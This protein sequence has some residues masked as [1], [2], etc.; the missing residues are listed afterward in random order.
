M[1]GNMTD[2][3]AATLHSL[4]SHGSNNG[5]VL[6]T[7]LPQPT[8]GESRP[9]SLRSETEVKRPPPVHTVMGPPLLVRGTSAD[10]GN[11]ME[12]PVLTTPNAVPRY[13]DDIDRIGTQEDLV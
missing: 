4:R 13:L 10:S 1:P 6:M 2:Y 3:Q 12:S 11:S 9:I 8:S 7:P 5:V